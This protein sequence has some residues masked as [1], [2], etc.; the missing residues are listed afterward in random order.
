LIGL[1]SHQSVEFCAR[2][3]GFAL[4]HELMIDQLEYEI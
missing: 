4:E 3:I 1:A 2:Q